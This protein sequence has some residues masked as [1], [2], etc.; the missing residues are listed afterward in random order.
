[1]SPD[2]SRSNS[3]ANAS[4]RLERHAEAR[5]ERM[6]TLGRLSGKARRAKR[7]KRERGHQ[8]EEVVAA[9]RALA[10]DERAEVLADADVA[11]DRRN[12]VSSPSRGAASA[13]VQ[14]DPSPTI[15]V[16]AAAA[17]PPGVSAF[18]YAQVEQVRR[19]R[20]AI[21]LPTPLAPGSD[22]YSHELAAQEEDER[23]RRERDQRRAA[24]GLPPF[25][26]EFS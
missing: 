17:Y 4:E 5:R 11:G 13:Y 23:Y 6:R 12:V 7:E 18:E 21:G 8:L 14:D 3:P 25:T 2:S 20:I 16:P 26:K 10:L 15:S 19:D 9:L 22:P 1:M 24:Q